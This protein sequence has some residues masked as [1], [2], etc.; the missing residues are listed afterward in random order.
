MVRW[1]SA[2]GDFAFRLF[3]RMEQVTRFGRT[4][5]RFISS[6][7]CQT[8]ARRMSLWPCANEWMS[9]LYV[10]ELG[11]QPDFFMVS[12][13]ER[14]RG[15][16]SWRR[17]ALIKVLYETTS[18]TR[19]PC[20]SSMS[21]SARLRSRHSTQASRVEF[22]MAGASS[23]PEARKA[24]NM[25]MTSGRSPLAAAW[26]SKTRCFG[27]CPGVLCKSCAANSPRPH[28]S[29]EFTRQRSVRKSSSPRFGEPNDAAAGEAAAG[30]AEGLAPA[31]ATCSS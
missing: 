16:L 19:L 15:T 23:A 18:A 7:T 8:W 27:V 26:R 20:I 25:R 28:F 22:Q 6:T 11:M 31:A 29:A 21:C 1:T 24:P 3:K 5:S 13:R 2:G 30:D 17:W 10:T 9:S 4:P 14:A 12:I